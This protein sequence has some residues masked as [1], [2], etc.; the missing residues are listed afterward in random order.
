MAKLRDLQS[1]AGGGA[2][3]RVGFLGPSTQPST[4]TSVCLS[5]N[6]ANAND[7]VKSNG[8]LGS[9]WSLNS[10]YVLCAYRL[11]R[12]ADSQL[13]ENLSVPL[14][15]THSRLRL[16][17]RP[18]SAT[19]IVATL[20]ERV[21]CRHERYVWIMSKVVSRPQPP[22]RSWRKLAGLRSVSAIGV[23][24]LVAR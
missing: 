17:R 14:F 16:D 4:G 23:C 15:A 8:L 9:G 11:T 5:I 21:T 6:H 22:S 7:D 10:T 18:R 3:L 19:S 13:L 12:I 20:A 24:K 2:C 1:Y